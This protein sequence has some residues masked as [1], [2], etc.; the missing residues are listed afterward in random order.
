MPS[1]EHQPTWETLNPTDHLGHPRPLQWLWDHTIGTAAVK[2]KDRGTGKRRTQ[3]RRKQSRTRIL[4]NTPFCNPPQSIAQHLLFWNSDCSASSTEH[5]YSRHDRVRLIIPTALQ[6][7]RTIHSSRAPPRGLW[8]ATFDFNH[9]RFTAQRTILNKSTSKSVF[10]GC[11]PIPGH[12]S[13]IGEFHFLLFPSNFKRGRAKEPR[14]APCWPRHATTPR[15]L[16]QQ[17]FTQQSRPDDI[18]NRICTPMIWSTR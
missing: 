13:L 12:M 10:F 15:L 8:P 1:P 9:S 6:H 18:T 3:R 5:T 2:D 16:R 7:L 17:Q 11:S 4:A 14:R